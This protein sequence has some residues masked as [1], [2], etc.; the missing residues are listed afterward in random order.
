MD[1]TRIPESS[2]KCGLFDGR[3]CR[4]AGGIQLQVML[5]LAFRAVPLIFLA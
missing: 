3:G 4:Q 5:G 1:I 2:V